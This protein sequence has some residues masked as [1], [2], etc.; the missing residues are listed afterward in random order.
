MV[1]LCAAI[2]VSTAARATMNAIAA[3][4]SHVPRVAIV[5]NFSDPSYARS[6]LKLVGDAIDLLE[7]TQAA[8]AEALACVDLQEAPHPAPHPRVGAVDMVA[9][10]PLSES[11]AA[12]L[13]PELSACD[14]LAGQL[15]RA[16]GDLG[17]PVVLY[18]RQ[19]G[20]TLLEAR[21]LTSFFRSVRGEAPREVTLSEPADFG[22]SGTEGTVPQRS[23]VAVVGAMTYVTNFNI[24]VVRASLD[25]CRAA[26][27][28]LRTEM[29][30][31][32]MALPHE[33]ESIEIGC[34]LQATAE[35]DSP[36]PAAVLDLVRERLPDEAVIS[37]SYVVGLTPADALERAA[38]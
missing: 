38:A 32:V 17:C 28:A 2:Y 27:A 12:Q 35:R 16:L 24:Q 8:A 29:G 13:G 19:R 9:F 6:S 31:Q 34:N 18:G 23:G 21:R 14:A 25:A 37:R 26:A 7:A 20:R 15:G 33:G 3:R 30:V 4:V 10:M 22:P 11:S 5:D 1:R 36:S